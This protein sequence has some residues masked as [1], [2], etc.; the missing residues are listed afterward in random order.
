[1]AML[2][3]RKL[4]LK[5]WKNFESVEVHLEDRMFLVG[6][7]AAGKSNLL[8]ALRFLRDLASVGGGSGRPFA[9]A[10]A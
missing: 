7:N 2:R 4:R 3:F 6:P 5:N 8:D 9:D 10:R 1:M